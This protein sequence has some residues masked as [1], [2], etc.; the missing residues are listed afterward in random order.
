MHFVDE[1]VSLFLSPL[2]TF[3][4]TGTEETKVSTLDAFLDLI[5]NMFPENLMQACFNQVETNYK[6]VKVKPLVAKS[7]RMS[8]HTTPRH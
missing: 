5:R 8:R 7:K 4:Q 3:Q 6:E 1:C 2:V